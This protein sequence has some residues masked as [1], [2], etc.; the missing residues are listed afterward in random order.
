[1]NFIWNIG[2]NSLLSFQHTWMTWE[3]NFKSELR[4]V[5][6]WITQSKNLVSD[7]N[8]FGIDL[9]Y[10]FMCGFYVG[11]SIFLKPY[12]LLITKLDIHHKLLEFLLDTLIIVSSA[13]LVS[14]LIYNWTFGLHMEGKLRDLLQYLDLLSAKHYSSAKSNT[15]FTNRKIWNIP[16]LTMKWCLSLKIRK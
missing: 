12:H 3:L 7:W 13:N 9:K 8:K 16:I 5:L 14:T 4:N 10:K 15:S 2:S 6:R 11:F 1:M